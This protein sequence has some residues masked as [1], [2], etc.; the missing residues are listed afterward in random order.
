MLQGF[1]DIDLR[2]TTLK[3]RD[4]Q[5]RNHVLMVT[6]EYGAR[7]IFDALHERALAPDV[8]LF[9]GARKNVLQFGWINGPAFAGI[10]LEQAGSFAFRHPRQEC[11]SGT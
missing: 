10:A 3:E 4:C 2:C 11:Q 7:E 1:A 6:H 5:A 8:A 9:P